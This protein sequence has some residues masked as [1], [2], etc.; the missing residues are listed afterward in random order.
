MKHTSNTLL[1]E[2]GEALYGP[3]WQSDLA[4]DLGITDRTMRRWAAGASEIPAGVQDD[5][6][7]LIEARQSLLSNVSRKLPPGAA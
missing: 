3:R 7:R 5:L 1:C 4:R 2:V 6:R